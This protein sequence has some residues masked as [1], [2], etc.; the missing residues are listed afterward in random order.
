MLLLIIKTRPICM[1]W[2]MSHTIY[3]HIPVEG[4]WLLEADGDRRTMFG[5]G[6]VQAGDNGLGVSGTEPEHTTRYQVL[7]YARRT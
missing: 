1:F 6:P 5:M 2:Y 7:L 3:L 4:G